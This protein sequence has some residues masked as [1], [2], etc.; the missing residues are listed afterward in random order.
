LQETYNMQGQQG[1]NM[2]G[3][4]MPHDNMQGGNI[5]GQQGY[6]MRG[7]NTNSTFTQ[8]W[9]HSSLEKRF[10]L[11]KCGLLFLETLD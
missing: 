6:N 5:Q 7:D 10:V 4:N 2:R 1:S 3:Y 11:S 9:H 8:P